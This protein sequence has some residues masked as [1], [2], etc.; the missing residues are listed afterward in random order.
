MQ[1]VHYALWDRCRAFVREVCC[2]R[3]ASHGL[4]HMEKV[5]EHALLV[6]SLRDPREETRSASFDLYRIIL[7]GMLHDV[8]DHKYDRDGSLE[9]K[10]D[11]FVAAESERLVGLA[12]A[13]L[14]NT[15]DAA[16]APALGTSEAPML[17]ADTAAA[18]AV[19]SHGPSRIAG[20]IR[21]A[22]KAVSYS[23][24]EQRGRRWFEQELPADW[25]FVRDCV[26]DADK[27][28]AIGSAGLLRCY[29]FTICRVKEAYEQ[30]QQQRALR[31]EGEGEKV[32][33]EEEEEAAE[34]GRQPLERRV[35][36]AVS[37]HFEEKLSRLLP[38]YIVTDV[39]KYL[40]APRHEE[41]CDLLA[42]WKSL[43]P[44]PATTYWR[45]APETLP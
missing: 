4:S 26:S 1:R 15:A 32:R 10:V 27:L 7:V 16:A 6:Y 12:N 29:E 36:Q 22:L 43:G 20:W 3:D 30:K 37:R 44:P 42:A 28:E 19:L 14:A 45:D 5:T 34:G 23:A 31:G 18:T 38:L 35:L 13:R 21:S 40:G 17:L 8:A 39:G 11:A 2:G 41:M 9:G 24:E 25:C 33:E